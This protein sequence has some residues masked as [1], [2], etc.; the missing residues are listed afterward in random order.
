MTK[1]PRLLKVPFYVIAYSANRLF[2]VSDDKNIFI[3]PVFSDAE[4]AEKYR[5]YFART[6]KLKLQL[7]V[8]EKA[9]KGLSL[10]QCASIS[11]PSL[12]YVA[13]NPLPPRM[14]TA[15]TELKT[16]QTLIRSL[17]NQYQKVRNHQTP[18]KKEDSEV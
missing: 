15:Q 7:C 2:S 11:C 16:I 1:T 13:I 6:F 9:E 12:R 3:L 5:Q 18:R 4:I 10:I 17:Q 8:V 14:G